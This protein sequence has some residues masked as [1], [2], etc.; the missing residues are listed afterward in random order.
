MYVGLEDSLSNRKVEA[1]RIPE[2]HTR[3]TLSD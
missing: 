2:I 1:D 3:K